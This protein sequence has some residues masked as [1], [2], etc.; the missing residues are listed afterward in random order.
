MM[1]AHSLLGKDRLR[2]ERFPT[3]DT[4]IVLQRLFKELTQT[5][6]MCAS[7]DELRKY[8]LLYGSNLLSFFRSHLV[9]RF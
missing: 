5:K 4:I 9:L 6:H 1:I 2:E 7:S 3:F 8:R